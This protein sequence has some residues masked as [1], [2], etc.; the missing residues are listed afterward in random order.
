MSL[1]KKIDELWQLKE[2]GDHETALTLVKNLRSEYPDNDRLFFLEGTIY[3]REG[4][5][6]RAIE[7]LDRAIALCPDKATLYFHRGEYNLCLDNI[8]KSMEDF[9]DAISKDNYN[10]ITFTEILYFYRAETFIKLGRKQE[11]LSDLSK[12]PENY[13]TWTFELRSKADLIADCNKL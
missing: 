10:D 1:D 8:L 2:K 12:I 5:Y 4:N 13:Q 7:C 6:K 9:S 11:A 3:A